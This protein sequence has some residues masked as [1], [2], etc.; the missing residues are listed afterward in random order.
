MP[1]RQASHLSRAWDLAAQYLSF[2]KQCLESLWH[3]GGWYNIVAFKHMQEVEVPLLDAFH[4]TLPMWQ[5]HMK[6]KDCSHYCS[7]GAYEVWTYLLTDMLK[8]TALR[9]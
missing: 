7:P 5:M 8:A 3:A 4:I 1:P 6:D 9:D 2:Q